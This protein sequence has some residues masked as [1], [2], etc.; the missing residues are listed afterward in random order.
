[1][2]RFRLVDVA[3]DVRPSSI[4]RR[5]FAAAYARACSTC[6]VTDLLSSATPFCSVDFLA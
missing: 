2:G 6:R 1:M 3:L 4:A 5:P